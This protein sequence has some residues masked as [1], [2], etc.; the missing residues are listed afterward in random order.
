[1]PCVEAPVGGRHKGGACRVLGHIPGAE[2][3]LGGWL[4]GLSGSHPLGTET[5][6][7]FVQTTWEL[8]RS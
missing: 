2:R 8:P 6:R 5:R 3:I 1:M 4:S 7:H